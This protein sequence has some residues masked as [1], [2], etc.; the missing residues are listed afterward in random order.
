[1]DGTVRFHVSK[2]AHKTYS[3]LKGG[4][5]LFPQMSDM[6]YWC[7]VLGFKSGQQR[8]TIDHKQDVVKWNAFSDMQKVVLEAIAVNDEGAFDVLPFSSEK[9]ENIARTIIEEYCELGF[10]HLMNI[11]G[12]VDTNLASNYEKLLSYLIENFELPIT[13][14][15]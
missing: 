14:E 12:N 11:I 7:T 1:M 13:S 6:F 2:S 8:R 10:N 5:E 3:S 15:D 9:K 4:E